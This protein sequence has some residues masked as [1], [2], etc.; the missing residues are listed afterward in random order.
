MIKVICDKC[1]AD[2]GL[3][4]YAL[5]VEVIHN[6]CPVH[7]FDVGDLKIT[8]DNTKLRMVLCQDCYR[9][10]GLPNVHKAVRD[11][12]LAWRDKPKEG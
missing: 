1:D 4:G 7:I 2:C 11:K 8:C 10:L 12:K 6:P 5:T 3:V 9:S